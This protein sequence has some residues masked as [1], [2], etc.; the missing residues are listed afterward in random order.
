MMLNIE[1]SP[2][3]GAQSLLS[4]YPAQYAIILRSIFM[5]SFSSTTQWAATYSGGFACQK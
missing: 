4:T 5:L 2:S 3:A 1:A